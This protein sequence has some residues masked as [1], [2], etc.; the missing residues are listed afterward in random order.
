VTPPTG[1]KTRPRVVLVTG[2]SGAGKA[3]VLRALEDLAY[4]AVDNAPLD[5]LEE[6][7]LRNQRRC[8]IGVDARTRGFDAGAVAAALQRLRANPALRAELIYVWADQETLLRRYTESRR[9]HP[10]A[11]QARV[12]DGIAAEMAL[13]APLRD[14]ADLMIDTTDLTLPA[15]RVTIERHFG[16]ENEAEE[17]RMA[18]SLI[19]FSYAHGLPREADLVFD[20]RFLRNPHYVPTLRSLTGRDS[21]VGAYIEADPD[22]PEFFD[23]LTGLTGLLLPR[24][25]QEGKKYATIA[26]GCTGGRHRSVHTVE[27]LAAALASRSE[28][29]DAKSGWRLHVTHRELAREG[30]A[31]A[32]PAERSP[33]A[34]RPATERSGAQDDRF[35]RQGDGFMP[36]P[37]QAQEA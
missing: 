9:R 29:G 35:Y 32:L 1:T 13:T 3:S 12:T 11:P 34:D 20:A 4:D 36:A 28:S 19:S 37:V 27:K 14:V 16:G 8:A 18:V 6:L 25:V 2:L 26:I 33:R 5:V 7:I 15:L 30:N 24:F 10:L 22:F 31:A 17:T 21:A 23:R